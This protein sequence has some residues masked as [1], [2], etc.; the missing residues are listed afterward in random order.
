MRITSNLI[1]LQAVP[2]GLLGWPPPAFSTGTTST[3]M[4][5]VDG[6]ADN[7]L[8]IEEAYHQAPGVVQPIFTA[9]YSLDSEGADS[10]N[11][12]L[13]LTQE[14]PLFSQK[15]QLSY[16]VPYHFTKTCGTATWV[17]V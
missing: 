5:K 4:R 2:L 1:M 17:P 7:S 16:T 9:F 11:W 6:I 8:L 12:N 13:A 10:R 14:W 15:H 3:T